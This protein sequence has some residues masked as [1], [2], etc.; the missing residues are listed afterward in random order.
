[1]I[2]FGTSSFSILVLDRL[3]ERGIAPLAIVTVPDRPAGRKLVMTAPPVKAWAEAHGIRCMQ[4]DKL[5]AAAVQELLS[6]G[7]GEERPE[8]FVVASYGK[9]IPQAVLD[10]PLCGT[11]NIHPS[12]L[13][14]YRGATPFQT[15]LLED[16][17]DTGVAIMQMDSKM[18]H[19]PI[20]A[21]KKVPVMPWPPK[22]DVLEKTLAESG[23]DM[24][25][26]LVPIYIKE[27]KDG[28]LAAGTGTLQL[29]EQDHAAATFTKKIEKADGLLSLEGSSA[30]I[31]GDAGR[32]ACLKHLGLAGWP[33]TY[34]F[35][36]KDGIE[37]R[38][39]IK[40]ARW[41]EER[42]I[43]EILRVTPEGKKE[44]SWKE[45]QNFMDMR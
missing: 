37:M 14:K 24:L 30:E 28:S 3:L 44:M 36:Q 10:V 23:A 7:E 13:P 16:D 18:D 20:I 38:V 35:M 4:F 8:L 22:L 41:D 11:L 43:F 6:S 2:F 19:G 27:M 17:S 1:M 42:K 21:I 15:A 33:G 25:A 9:I 39:S 5:D 12:L 34:F 40:E 29:K 32:K 26:E 31:Q 45:F